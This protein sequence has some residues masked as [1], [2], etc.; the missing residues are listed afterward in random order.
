[1]DTLHS[2][3]A[4]EASAVASAVPSRIDEI[5]CT[6][7]SAGVLYLHIFDSA[8]LPADT[9]AP[10]LCIAVPATSTVSWDPERGD[11]RDRGIPFDA[12]CAVCLSTTAATKTV[13]TAVG[14]F[15]VRGA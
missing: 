15:S 9:T 3:A 11:S 13:A 4:L 14:V 6:N 7:T 5:I 8:T 10:D 12:G 1:M 2:S